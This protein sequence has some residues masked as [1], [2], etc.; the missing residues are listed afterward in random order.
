MVL[1]PI[2]LV[3]R[4]VGSSGSAITLEGDVLVKSKEP[5]VVLQRAPVRHLSCSVWEY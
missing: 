4:A 1:N 2:T 5:D 3:W